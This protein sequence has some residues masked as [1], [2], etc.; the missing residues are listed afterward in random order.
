MML[1]FASIALLNGPRPSVLTRTLR[2]IN[3]VVGPFKGAG[4]KPSEKMTGG[5]TG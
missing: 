5:L 2:E 1:P 3:P 4:T